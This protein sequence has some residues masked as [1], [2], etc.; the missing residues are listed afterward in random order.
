MPNYTKAKIAATSIFD[1]VH[2]HSKIDPL[3]E[4][5]EKP[6]PVTGLPSISDLNFTYAS[7]R[8]QPVLRSLNIPKP[9]AGQT[10]AIVGPSGSGKSTIVG[11]LERFFDASTGQACLDDIDIKLWNPRYLR[12]HMSLVGQEPTLLDGTIAEVPS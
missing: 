4:D 12:S 6:G 2:R 8:N 3:V 1:I 5:G 7:R 9:L 10:V 11:I